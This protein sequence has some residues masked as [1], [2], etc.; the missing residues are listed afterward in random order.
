MT[1]QRVLLV[2]A[3]ICFGLATIGVGARVNLVAL[4]LACWAAAELL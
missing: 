4:G 3:V 2:A 1:V